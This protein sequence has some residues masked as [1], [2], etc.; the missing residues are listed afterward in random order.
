MRIADRIKLASHSALS[1]G[2]LIES[3]YLI[4]FL[5]QLPPAVSVVTCDAESSTSFTPSLGMNIVLAWAA[6]CIQTKARF[7]IIKQ[8]CNNPRFLMHQIGVICTVYNNIKIIVPHFSS[9]EGH[10]I[11]VIYN[12]LLKIKYMD[13]TNVLAYADDLI[14]ATRGNSI[15]AVENYTNVE[16]S[17][18]NGWAKNNKIKFNDTKSKVIL[19]SRRKC[20]KTRTL[21]N[22]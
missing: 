19:V 4:S 14:M 22:T 6:I 13:R 12:Y 18:I 11:Y 5:Q 9:H 7:G 21:Q 15:R 20:K 3:R 2:N 1:G 8:F 16:L 10:E 17:K